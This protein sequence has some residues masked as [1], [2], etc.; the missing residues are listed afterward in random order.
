MERSKKLYTEFD[1]EMDFIEKE[2]N[3]ITADEDVALA[4]PAVA[5]IVASMERQKADLM[6]RKTKL[7]QQLAEIDKKIEKLDASIATKKSV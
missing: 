7:S 2:L 6:A 4:N 5:N 3:A 1:A